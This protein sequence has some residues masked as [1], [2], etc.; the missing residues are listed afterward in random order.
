MDTEN[1]SSNMFYVWE[2]DTGRYLSSHKGQTMVHSN[3]SIFFL[4]CSK[5]YLLLECFHMQN[6]T[7]L[8]LQSGWPKPLLN[9]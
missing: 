3:F 9:P 7:H 1:Q 2:M 4:F 6:Y 8:L 5:F